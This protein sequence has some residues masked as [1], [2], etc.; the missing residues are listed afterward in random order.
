M[1]VNRRQRMAAFR[2]GFESPL[3][4]ICHR[5]LGSACSKRV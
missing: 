5:S 4:S 1:I 2:V 3:K